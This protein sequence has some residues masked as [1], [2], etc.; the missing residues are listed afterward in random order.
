MQRFSYKKTIASREYYAILL[1]SLGSLFGIAGVIRGDTR[2]GLLLI[3]V[4]WAVFLP[5]LGFLTL[6]KS[7][8]VLTEDGVQR[9]LFGFRWIYVPWNSI[10]RLSEFYVYSYYLHRKIHAFGLHARKTQNTTSFGARRIVF[11]ETI[12]G[13]WELVTIIKQRADLPVEGQHS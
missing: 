7:D 9:E 8:V 2:A 4:W 6:Y 12:D 11:D 1:L 13:F 5:L 3:L 10:D